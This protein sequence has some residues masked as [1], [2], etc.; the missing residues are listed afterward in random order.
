MVGFGL[1]LVYVVLCWL[2]LLCSVLFRFPFRYFCFVLFCFV[3]C[4]CRFVLVLFGVVC[5]CCGG[6]GLSLFCFVFV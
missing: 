3:M 1:G 2:V 5:V 4:S 6:S